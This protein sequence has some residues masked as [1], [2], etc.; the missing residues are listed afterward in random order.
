MGEV[1]KAISKPF[2]AITDVVGSAVGGDV[3]AGIKK[4]GQAIF[5]P[6]NAAMGEGPQA[7]ATPGVDPRMESLKKEQERQAQEFRGKMPQMKEQTLSDVAQ[8]EK[9]QLAGQLAGIKSGAQGRGLLYSGQR[10]GAELGA[11]AQS[12]GKIAK[13]KS[14]INKSFEDQARDMEN[15]AIDSGV[16]LQ[17]SQAGIQNEVFNQALSNMRERSANLGALGGVAGSLIGGAMGRK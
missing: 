13:A 4:G 6:F 15:A 7:P 12:A 17:K 14:D 1:T 16:A 8:Q 9:G 2:T 10:Q 5:D 3:G 11:K